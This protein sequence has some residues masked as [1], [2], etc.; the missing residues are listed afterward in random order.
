MQSGVWLLV[1][2]QPMW[3]WVETPPG[4]EGVGIQQQVHGGPSPSHPTQPLPVPA[5]GG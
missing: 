4:P 2:Q 1:G 5:G 3:V